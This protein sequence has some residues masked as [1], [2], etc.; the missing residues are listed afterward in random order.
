M[1]L[2]YGFCLSPPLPPSNIP[3]SYCDIQIF[4]NITEK[5]TISEWNLHSAANKCTSRLLY[6]FPKVVFGGP[7]NS[8]HFCSPCPNTIDPSG[9]EHW[10]H[11]CFG[12]WGKFLPK[13]FNLKYSL[14]R[15]RD[16]SYFGLVAQSGNDLVH[17]A[18]SSTCK[19]CLAV[20][21]QAFW[22]VYL[23]PCS[24]VEKQRSCL[25]FFSSP[26]RFSTVGVIMSHLQFK[27]M[28]FK[29]LKEMH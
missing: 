12:N 20:L 28:T 6:P 5:Q 8:L 1:R 14:L 13:L 3:Q 25:L 2:L 15:I 26:F 4:M 21:S 27:T 19:K 16:A 29:H 24:S 9:H 23:A 17:Q 7:S 11:P 18:C 10:N 22:E